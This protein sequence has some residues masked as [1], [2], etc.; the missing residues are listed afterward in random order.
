[1]YPSMRRVC[2]KKKKSNCRKGKHTKIGAHNLET[3]HRRY[4]E[5]C[6]KG[7]STCM[8][9]PLY[10]LQFNSFF[11]GSIMVVVL[12]VDSGLFWHLDI[13]GRRLIV[14]LLY[15]GTGGSPAT[16]LCCILTSLSRRA[17]STGESRLRL[18]FGNRRHSWRFTHA[19][20]T[21]WRYIPGLSRSEHE[22]RLGA[23]CSL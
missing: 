16:C 17:V 20:L 10:R 13:H 8:H 14:G 21:N 19:V 3:R 9:H 18:T 11:D 2:K 15:W 22:R 12:F 4:E 7:Q 23:Y 5:V 6:R 1:M